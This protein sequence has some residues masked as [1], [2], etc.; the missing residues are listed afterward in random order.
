ML[1]RFVFL[2]LFASV[3]ALA[4]TPVG[5]IAGQIKDPSSAVVAGAVVTSISAADGGKRS[6]TS[7]DQGFF[8]I[9]TLMPGEYKVIVEAKG[10]R[11]YEVPRVSVGVG[12]TARVDVTLT[13]GTETVTV[14]VASEAATVNTEQATVG[15]VVTTRQIAELPLNGRNYLELA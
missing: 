3:A 7:N 4:Q 1:N 9:P 13:V 2:S 14:E 8:L 12:Q 5:A 6:V 11:T 10:F 15:G